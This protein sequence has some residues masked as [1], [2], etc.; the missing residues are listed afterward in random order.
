MSRRASCLFFC[1]SLASASPPNSHPQP[2]SLLIGHVIKAPS[3]RPKSG[4]RQ[5]H[6][7]TDF[8]VGREQR[9][10]PCN[11]LPGNGEHPSRRGGSREIIGVLERCSCLIRGVRVRGGHDQTLSSRERANHSI[12]MT[13]PAACRLAVS[14]FEPS[15]DVGY[16]IRKFC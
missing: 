10:S 16:Q 8:R 4:L 9:S 15:L 14:P 11:R 1:Y 13:P 6:C 7:S 5:T 3:R 12:S 2:H